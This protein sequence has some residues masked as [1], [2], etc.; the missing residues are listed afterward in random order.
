[1]FSSFTVSFFYIGTLMKFYSSLKEVQE[2]LR[3]KTVTVISLVEY[4]LDRINQH[5][6]LNAFNE[7]FADEAL[8][9]AS[10]IDQKLK[11]GT[12]GRLAGMIICIK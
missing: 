11:E 1:M 6:N 7:V 5:Q 8:R 2:D 10:F 12:A 3:N 9:N 4:Y